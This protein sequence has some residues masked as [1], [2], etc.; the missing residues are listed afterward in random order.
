VKLEVNALMNDTQTVFSMLLEDMKEKGQTEIVDLL[1]KC[2]YGFVE[3]GYDNWDGGTYF[4]TLYI[5]L[6]LPIINNLSLEQIK[7]WQD[8]IANSAGR[9]FDEGNISLSECMIVPFNELF[10]DWDV[11]IEHCSPKELI[12]RVV[13]ESRLLILCA[14]GTS[15]ADIEAEYKENHQKLVSILSLTKGQDL[16]FSFESLWQWY[17]FYK[18][19]VK[20]DLSK[21]D[22]R[23]KYVLDKY[24]ATVS[25]LQKS[26]VRDVRI[27]KRS[28]TDWEVIE[29]SLAELNVKI[30][31]IKDKMTF[32]EIG[33]RCRE[34]IIALANQVYNEKEHF[35]FLSQDKQ[36]DSKGN[37]IEHISDTDSY[38]KLDCYVNSVLS[39]GQNVTLR[40]YAKS[41]IDLANSMTHIET[42]DF[43]KAK[44][45]INATM[46]LVDMVYS[47]Y[48]R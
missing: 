34:T 26:Y 27:I 23:R 41:T 16:I 14:T 32:N 37:R 11:I 47:I 29:N 45:C 15:I 35:S 31:S 2:D 43:V 48:K 25:L 17:E 28:K 24:N 46:S 18:N 42:G 21:Y 13:N 44:L 33:V 12:D 40:G 1:R 4:Y 20:E 8:V 30:Y 39:G 19:D 36:F 38:R 5:Y 10:I 3:T 7:E 22:S 6:R 9:F